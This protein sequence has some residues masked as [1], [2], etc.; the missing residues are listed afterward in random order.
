MYDYSN[1]SQ[2]YGTE[3]STSILEP[4][5]FI[6]QASSGKRFANYIIDYLFFYAI[7]FV[8]SMTI[9]YLFPSGY[10]DAVS[11]A[12]ITG[13]DIIDTILNLIIFGL[14]MF[15]LEALFKGKSIG[16]LFTGTRAVNEDGTRLTLHNALMRGLVRSVPFDGLSALGSPSYPW[17]DKWTKTYVIDEKQSQLEQ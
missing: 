3:N 2:H 17:H 11:N 15:V 13:S 10:L 5:K 16:K 6:V 8:G 4:E 7:L 12:T 14:Y 9:A 1:S